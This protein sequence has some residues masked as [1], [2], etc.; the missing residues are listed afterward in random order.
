MGVI[1]V[2]IMIVSG[3]NVHVH[4]RSRLKTGQTEREGEAEGKGQRQPN[5]IVTVELEFGKE[6]ARGD[7]D[8]HA[9]RE[10]Q[11]PRGDAGHVVTGRTNPE[12][13]DSCGHQH[14]EKNIGQHAE[15]HRSAAAAHQRRQRHRIEGLVQDDDQKRRQPCKGTAMGDDDDAGPEG[16][17]L[18]EA[19]DAEPGKGSDPSDRLSLRT[20]VSVRVEVPVIAAGVVMMH[21]CRACS[22]ARVIGLRLMMME[23]E[24]PLKEKERE[25]AD[26]RQEHQ[27]VEKVMTNRMAVTIR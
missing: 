13:P 1:M 7:A 24:E 20:T 14:R 4:V 19:V 26:H 5:P 6:I 10:G 27:R 18:Q 17:A 25:E 8:E 15:P 11:R 12:E 3:G 22:I 21:V 2:V 16:D 23:V 9:R